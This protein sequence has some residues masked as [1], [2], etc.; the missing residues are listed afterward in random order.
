M[1]TTGL[2]WTFGWITMVSLAA[3]QGCGDDD[4]DDGGGAT[5]GS[6]G[7]AGEDTGGSS[8]SSGRG[9]SSSGGTSSGGGGGRGGTSSGGT[10]G[11]MP[12]GMGGEGGEAVGG[13]G[14]GGDGSGDR[15]AACADYCQTYFDTGCEAFDGNYYG[16]ESQCATICSTSNWTLG[17]EGDAAGNSVHCRLT[18]A[19]FAA[20]ATGAQIETH[21]GHASANSTG[22]CVN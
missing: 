15:E 19:G 8:G 20:D 14:G 21:C 3:M 4:G 22:Q 6:G 16:N 1:K 18:H 13:E 2:Y 17:E 7:E 9:G 5:G 11:S 12:G 10:A